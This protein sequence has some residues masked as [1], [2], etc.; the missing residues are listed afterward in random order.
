[1]SG[2]IPG[3]RLSGPHRDSHEPGGHDEVRNIVGV[4]DVEDLVQ[5]VKELIEALPT[6]PELESV[7][8]TRY[9]ELVSLLG[10]LSVPIEVFSP[11]YTIETDPDVHFTEAISGGDAERENIT[12]L[13]CNKIRITRITVINKVVQNSNLFL[14]GKDTFEEAD[15]DDDSYQVRMWQDLSG[16]SR[17]IGGVGWV[18]YDSTG[19][20]GGSVDMD[21]EDEDGT[22]EL[23]LAYSPTGDK[24]AGAAG[25][26]KLRITYI[27][28][29]T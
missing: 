19:G 13:V 20:Y 6:N 3:D 25:E 27:P 17:K 7:A 22:K 5:E 26:V 2:S 11:I 14:F 9:N 16:Y 21:Y 15:M 23:H 4:Q 29:E 12:G 24:P 1:M 10:P 18:Y 28:R 8:L